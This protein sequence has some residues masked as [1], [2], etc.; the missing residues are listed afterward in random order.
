MKKTIFSLQKMKANGEKITMITAYDYTMGRVLDALGVDVVLVGDS[1]GMTIKGEKSTLAVSMQ[2]MIY[3]AK[4]V[5]KGISEAF[6]LVDMPFGSY[7]ISGKNALKN[8]A[9]LMSEGGADAL[10][11]E[12]ADYIKRA[13]AIVKAGI[14]VMMH[15]GLTPQFS[16]IL[17]GFKLQAK[18]QSAAKRLIEDAKRA[19]DVG[20]FGLLLECVPWQVAQIITQTLKIP[21][22]GIGAGRF[23]DGQVLVWH[24]ILGLNLDFKP[25]FVKTFLDTK[26]GLKKYLAAVRNGDFPSD[27]FSFSM[28]ENELKGLLSDKI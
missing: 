23:C 15:L 21:V 24:D 6:L 17:G 9:R 27:E 11:I 1:L 20:C 3:H 12:G 25:K 2:D 7:Q 18:E 13:G 4:L 22:I 10:K 28:S 19:E 16:G 14:P 26:K 8:A 5:S